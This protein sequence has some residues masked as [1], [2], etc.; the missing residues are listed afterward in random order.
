MIRFRRLAT[1]VLAM[2]LTAAAAL[3]SLAEA[4]ASPLDVWGEAAIR[5]P[6]GP[7]YDFFADRK[8]TRLNSSH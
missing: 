6:N 1:L 2:P 4:I 8:S 3:P 7:S 5:Q